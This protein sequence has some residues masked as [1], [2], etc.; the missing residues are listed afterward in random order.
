M[1]G[2]EEGF[3]PHLVLPATKLTEGECT[4]TAAKRL[5]QNDLPP[6]VGS[7]MCDSCNIVETEMKSKL[8]LRTVYKKTTYHMSLRPERTTSTS[9]SQEVEHPTTDILK[10]LEGKYVKRNDDREQI[11]AWL[12]Q[13]E[14]EYLQS[15][16]ASAEF[17]QWLS[18]YTVP[19]RV[20]F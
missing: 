11:F 10:R 18:D 7:L 15:P 1:G 3:V 14:F 4:M 19:P 9:I 5:M 6:L 12:T 17:K 2:G 13:G 8:G 16:P 20:F